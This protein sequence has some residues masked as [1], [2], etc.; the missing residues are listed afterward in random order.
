MKTSKENYKNY[1]AGIMF[2]A[3]TRS[4]KDQLV[5]F[6]KELLKA[7]DETEVIAQ[8][9]D[10]FDGSEVLEVTETLYQDILAHPTKIEGLF[11]FPYEIKRMKAK[12][13]TRRYSEPKFYYEWISRGIPNFLLNGI[14]KDT[15]VRIK[16]EYYSDNPEICDCFE[17]EIL[18][19]E[20][21]KN[22]AFKY[23]GL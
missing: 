16:K 4:Q 22:A 23:S 12:Y 19:E 2:P 21:L 8:F 1:I 11:F 9:G 10:D 20:E 5:L 17:I 7:Y 6:K 14:K 3:T 18:N 15:V 13:E